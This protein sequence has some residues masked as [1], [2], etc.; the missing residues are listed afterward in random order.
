M[1]NEKYLRLLAKEYPN[2]PSIQGELIRLKGLGKLPKGTEYFFSDLHGEDDAFIHMLRSA[3]GNIRVKIDERFDGELSEDEQNH[4]ANLVY[5][6]E[7][8]LRIMRN[9]GR[10]DPQWLAY[11]V[12]RLI[13]LCRHISVKYRRGAIEEKMPEE[14]A[15]ILRELLFTDTTDPFR[16]DYNSEVISYIAESEIV[17]DFIIGLCVMIQKVCVN[18]VHII[19]DI[20]DRG[21]GPHKIMEELIDFGNVD[22][23]WG[24]HDALWMGAAAGNLVSMCCV[25][26]VGIGYNTFDTFE[27]GYGLNLRAL[28]AFAQEVYGDDP[29]E[30]FRPKTLYQNIYDQVEPDL[31]ARMQKAVAILQFKLES[32]MLDRNPEWG[33]PER[34]VLRRT[35]FRRM[36][37]KDGDQE[38]PLLDTNFP[39][40]DPDDPARLT[41]AE[42]ELLR[43]IEG[44]FLASETLRRHVDFLYATGSTYLRANGNLLYHGCVPLTEDGEFDGLTMDGKFYAGRELFDY[45][46]RQMI[47][48]Y[49]DRDGSEDH[50][51]AVDFMWYTWIGPLSPLFGKSKMSTFENYFVADK[52]VRKE[53]YNPYYTLYEDPEMCNKI[54]EE[55]DVPA[56]T[57]HI[58]NGHVPVKIKDGETPLKGGGKLYVIDGGISK[59]YQPKTGIAG[60][61]LIFNSHALALAEHTT[62]SEIENDMGSYTPKLTVTEE[63]PRRILTEDTDEGAALR[64]RMTDLEELMDAYSKGLIKEERL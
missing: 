24:N 26:R 1:Q 54:L 49:Y 17:W 22:V 41:P 8:V 10:A 55:F 19:G 64:E 63:M 53:V 62:F 15:S 7:N 2:I 25:L 37:F 5:Q 28:S 29:C 61:T 9:D 11:A 51:K 35:D 14:Y 31:A 16:R 43:S 40:I 6:P 21:N 13:E 39:T 47:N 34:N 50:R 44:S 59:A 58:F 23:Q 48:A 45:V 30:R 27:H 52:A 38:L 46:E 12:S 20:F 3:S 36:V 18:V 60:Y 32:Q 42:E 56:E 33:I 57:G 4:L